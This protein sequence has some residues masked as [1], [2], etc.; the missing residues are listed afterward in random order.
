MTKADLI[1]DVV[2]CGEGDILRREAGEM[3]EAVFGIMKETLGKGQKLKISGFGGFMIR[4]KKRR[5]GRNPKTG[6]PIII[7]ARR[8][9]TF[10]SS[11]V[12]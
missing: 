1:D 11:P 12:L 2:D 6:D 5:I 10:K 8:G 9:L 7:K 4:D 3:V